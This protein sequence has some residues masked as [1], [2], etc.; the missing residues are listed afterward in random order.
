MSNETVAY[1]LLNAKEFGLDYL[2]VFDSETG[3]LL[4]ALKE[5]KI[6]DLKQFDNMPDAIRYFIDTYKKVET[7]KGDVKPE[8]SLT[9]Y[10]KN[11][12]ED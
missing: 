2:L 12:K 5:E 7:G 9:A 11:K 4:T 8:W 3:A 6:T 10:N 1:Y